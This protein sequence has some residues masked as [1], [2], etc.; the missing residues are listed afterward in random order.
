MWIFSKEKFNKKAL[1]KVEDKTMNELDGKEVKF[2]S[3][4]DDF[5]ICKGHSIYREWCIE[6]EDNH[7]RI[8]K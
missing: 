4:Y 3:D 6:V 8:K 1:L 2:V 7:E 5:G